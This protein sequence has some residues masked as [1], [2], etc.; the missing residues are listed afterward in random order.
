M[1]KIM[2]SFLILVMGFFLAAGTGFCEESMTMERMKNAQIVDT[3]RPIDDPRLRKAENTDRVFIRL[4]NMLLNRVS[5][6][7]Q[8]KI[9]QAIV[10][11]NF[12]RY[13]FNTETSEKTE[14]TRKWRNDLPDKLPPIIDQSRAES[15]VNGEI[16]SIRLIYISPE[17]EIFKI[18][19]VP[20]NPCWII[21]TRIDDSRKV[22]IIDAVSGEYLGQGLPAPYEGFSMH[23]PDHPPDCD[24]NN[25]LWYS[26]AQNAHNWFETMDYDTIRDGSAY[27]SVVQSH[28]QSDST[29]MFYE[30]DHGGATSFKNRCD[31]DILASEIDTWINGYAPMGFAF[32]GSC[33]GLSST[34]NGTFEH[35]FRKEGLAQDTVV[36][37]YNGMS[38]S[39][40]EDDCWGHAIAWQTKLFSEMNDGHTVAYAYAQANLDY[41]DCT[42]EGRFCMLYRGDGNLKFAGTGVPKVKRSISGSIYNIV[43]TSPIYL[44]ISPLPGVPSRFYHRPYFVRASITVPS[45]KHLTLNTTSTNKYIDLAFLNSAK[46]IM[47]GTYLNANGS[48]GG[49]KFVSGINQ[50]KGMQFNGEFK[51]YDGGEIRVYE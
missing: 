9:G 29:V 13:K 25:P 20:E 47:D 28:I 18:T 41:P 38:L 1:N 50:N 5:F 40:C 24:D 11:K 22:I 3:I 2:I 23:G 49:V 42:D 51:M 10:E 35:E 33:M 34:G 19:P 8:R 26:H 43:I 12:I 4:E 46:L 32:I 14:E 17:S 27:G 6:F 48:H 37:G 31:D 7:H 21:R 30:L 45:T 36:V 16:L 39:V 15:Q 44:D